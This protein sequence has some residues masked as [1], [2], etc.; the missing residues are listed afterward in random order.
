MGRRKLT[1]YRDNA[2]RLSAGA[3]ARWRVRHPG[4]QKRAQDKYLKKNPPDYAKVRKAD[5]AWCDAHP[6]DYLLRG[7]RRRAKRKGIPFEITAADIER[8]EFCPVL[9][10]RLV[11]G[12]SG[13]SRRLYENGAAASLDRIK[14]ERGYVKNN[15]LIVSL[16]ANLL[17]GQASI[18]ELQ[19]IAAFYARFK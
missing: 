5:V 19:K 2:H 10:L 3:S 9:G 12:A 8:P 7:A 15:V 14:N 16:R 4:A 13:K 11:Y 1:N 18:A 17:K 6:I